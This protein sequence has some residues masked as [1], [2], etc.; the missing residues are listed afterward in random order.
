[1]IP[2]G[3]SIVYCYEHKEKISS[4]IFPESQNK[5]NV[6]EM[7]MATAQPTTPSG[8]LSDR[9]E[10]FFGRY[11]TIHRPIPM[12]P[13]TFN[14]TF[15]DISVER[16]QQIIDMNKEIVIAYSGGIDSTFV[17]IQFL[18]LLTNTSRITL[19]MDQNG[20][21]EN[22]TFYH[23]HIKNKLNII[24][25]DSYH[26]RFKP[27]ADQVMVSGDQI[28]QIFNCTLSSILDNRFSDWKPWAIKNFDS[29]HKAQ[30]FL[31][32][33]DPWLKKAPFEITTIFDYA[34]WAGFS[35]RWDNSRCRQLKW[36][37]SYD[38]TIYDNN[39]LSFFRTDDY[40]LWSIFNHDKKIKT[41]P[42]SFK[43]VMKDDIFNF[44]GNQDY[45]DSKTSYPSNGLGMNKDSSFDSSRKIEVLY[46]NDK[47]PLIVDNNLNFFFK[48][49]LKNNASEFQKILNPIDNGEWY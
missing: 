36:N 16:A 21:K 48:S 1:M 35:L 15:A 17:L 39:V 19:I 18:K 11:K 46:N 12:I 32:T 47:L 45:Y 14:K 37:D 26:A 5:I 9:T 27:T 43:Y 23:E 44:D 20:I 40:Q 31:E 34:W 2:L 42:E 29:V 33:I 10:T 41:T 38:K 28:P 24:T 6:I 30:W 3:D 22:P 7:I 4:I 8:Q 25:L 13:T 49:D